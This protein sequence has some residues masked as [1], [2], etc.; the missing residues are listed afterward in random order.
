MLGCR[1]ENLKVGSMPTAYPTDPRKAFAK[2]AIM[3]S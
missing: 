2:F 1:I 3:Q